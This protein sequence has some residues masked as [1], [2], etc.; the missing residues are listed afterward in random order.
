M[1]R[2]IVGVPGRWRSREAIVQAIN[3]ATS[4][5]FHADGTT[6]LDAVTQ[7][8]FELDVYDRDPNLAEAFAIAGSRTLSKTQLK[9]IAGH[10]FTVYLIGE[11][12][13]VAGAR[14]ML[15]AANHLLDAGGLA[16]KIETTGLAH[17]AEHWHHFAAS[18][19]SVSLC[20]AFVTL[21]G[22]EAEGMYYSCGMH[23]FGLPDASVVG[24]APEEAA[25]VLTTFNQWNL[26]ERPKLKDGDWFATGAQEQGFRFSLRPYGYDPEELLNNPFGRWHLEPS[27]EP[28]PV[29]P[30]SDTSGEPLFMAFKD[31]DP[32]VAAAVA[33]ARATLDYFA[34]HFDHPLEYGTHLFKA[35][36]VDGDESAHLWLGL[37][38]VTQKGFTGELFETPPEFATLHAGTQLSI[39]KGAVED[40]AIIQSGT[41]IGGFSMRLQRSKLP[42]SKRAAYDLHSGTLSRAPLEEIPGLLV[43][44]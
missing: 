43:R 7:A 38:A 1:G 14:A 37:T 20:R 29:S 9:A 18:G 32:E 24:I 12:A 5:R 40:W 34:A 31:D 41:L 19:S 16:V 22:S 30:V 26:I 44:T 17:P 39:S 33:Q 27:D 13:S 25:D 2:I 4:S 15:F 42:K 36:L 11:D 28:C 23:N 6:L 8:T 35:K 10:T 3:G 21:V